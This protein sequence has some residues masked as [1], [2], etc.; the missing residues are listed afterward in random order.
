MALQREAGEEFWLAADFQSE[1]IRL[2][3][4]K[5]FFHHLAQLVYLDGKHSAVMALVIKF[6]DRTLKCLVNGLDAMA[7]NILKADEQGEF[8][9]PRLGLLNHVGQVH[10]STCFLQRMRHD[11]TGIV[12]VKILR[13]PALDVI[14][15][16]GR[17][18]GPRQRSVTRMVHRINCNVRTIK[19]PAQKSISTFIKMQRP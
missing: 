19:S 2:A 13:A 12:D 8:Q 15:R 9:A 7:Q 16:A 4:V 17:I 1:I 18:Y 14:K 11:A 3:G 6:G 5:N 10:G